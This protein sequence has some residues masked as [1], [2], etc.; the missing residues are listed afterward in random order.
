VV[1]ARILLF[2]I[3]VS[4]AVGAGHSQSADTP[5]LPEP[6]RTQR[7]D[8]LAALEKRKAVLEKD[9]RG[10]ERAI[11]RAKKEPGAKD[12]AKAKANARRQSKTRQDLLKVLFQIDCVKAKQALA[13]T[14]VRMVAGPAPPPEASPPA[15]KWAPTK[16]AAPPP[17]GAVVKPSR[18]VGKAK[19]GEEAAGAGDKAGAGRSAD[20]LR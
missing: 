13:E 20:A 11:A 7:S 9:K 12:E 17:P 14:E 16:E 6:C 18:S 1:L 2:V 10:L 8:D 5:G 4:A 19:V 15:P 3:A